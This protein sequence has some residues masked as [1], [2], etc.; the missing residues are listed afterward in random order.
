MAE[1]TGKELGI[2]VAMEVMGWVEYGTSEAYPRFDA[3]TQKGTILVSFE[4]QRWRQRAPW[5]DMNDARGVVTEIAKQRF[6]VR[7]RFISALR[8]MIPKHNISGNCVMLQ[9]VD[10][11]F[12]WMFMADWPEAILQAA[13][14][15]VRSQ[16]NKERKETTC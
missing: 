9:R 4:G 10:F 3:M 15:A 6:S 14:A 1:L 5:R 2:A 8:Q 7:H 11:I 16:K 12:W 13:L